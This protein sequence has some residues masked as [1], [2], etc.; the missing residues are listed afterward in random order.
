MRVISQRELVATVADMWRQVYLDANGKWRYDDGKRVIYERLVA[1]PPTR[2]A[3]D[4]EAVIG[5]RSWTDIRCDECDARVDVAIEVGQ[6][7]DYES[8]TA[9]I[10][11]DCAKKAVIA[12]EAAQ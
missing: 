3:D 12:M 2:T 7:P 6:V 1:L 10:C 11:L 5:N 9:T 4:I 8:H